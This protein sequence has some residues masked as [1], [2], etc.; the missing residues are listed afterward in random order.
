MVS[1]FCTGICSR[2]FRRLGAHAAGPADAVE[3]H[4]HPGGQLQGAEGLGHVVVGPP[5][6]ADDLGLLVVNG[7]EH[8]HRYIA[9][10]VVRLEL[11]EHLPAVHLGHHDVED[12]EVGIGLRDH[13]QALLSVRGQEDLVVIQLEVELDH[14]GDGRIV[15]DEEYAILAPLCARSSSPRYPGSGCSN[16]CQ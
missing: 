2:R 11:H 7:R 15:L 8:D 14:V 1:P 3:D 4:L 13:V 5:A 16:Q 6:Q 12:N 9:G 10:L